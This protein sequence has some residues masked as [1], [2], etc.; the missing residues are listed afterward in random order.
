MKKN[1]GIIV[2]AIVLIVILIGVFAYNN[3]KKPANAGTLYIGI[4]D[5]T[6]DIK[7]V[8]D[9]ALSVKAVEVKSGEGA[10]V[11]VASDEKVYQLLALDASGKTELY[12]KAYVS[13]GT[14]DKVRVTLGDVVVKTKSK[15]DIKA[16]L[17][18]KQV[19][20]DSNIVVKEKANTS[21]KLDILADQSLHTTNKGEYVFASV[22]KTEARSEAS[23]S[24][25]GESAVDSSGGTLDQDATFGVDLSGKARK[26]FILKTGQSLEMETSSD[27]SL[28]FLLGGEVYEDSNK[29]D[30]DSEDS[31]ESS[32]KNKSYLEVQDSGKDSQEDK[33]D[34]KGG[35]REDEKGDDSKSSLDVNLNTG[36]KF[37]QE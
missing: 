23:V 37:I 11:K 25:S 26:D 7:D 14:Y 27:G 34:D 24:V 17:P 21:V 13:A 4:T 5:A 33:D 18:S 9:I 8:N 2:G 20:I 36:V 22:I 10:W 35:E 15:G 30:D 6:A 1:T 31:L 16:N 12:A 3:G 29:Y 28:K 32:S 19:I